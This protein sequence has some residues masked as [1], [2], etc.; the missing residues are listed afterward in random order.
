MSRCVRV[1]PQLC[2]VLKA[3]LHDGAFVDTRQQ[4][5]KARPTR[6]LVS[7]KLQNTIPCGVDAQGTLLNTEFHFNRN[8]RS[9]ALLPYLYSRFIRSSYA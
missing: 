8:L 6:P 5:D 9:A 1:I 2:A 3:E 7:L 4:A